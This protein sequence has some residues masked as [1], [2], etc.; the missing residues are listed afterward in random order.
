MLTLINKA[1]PDVAEEK[2]T[3]YETTGARIKKQIAPMEKIKYT[4]YESRLGT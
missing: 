4:V 2:S 1:V 3:T